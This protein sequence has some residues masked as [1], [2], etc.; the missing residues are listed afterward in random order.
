MPSTDCRGTSPAPS[1]RQPRLTI[2]RAVRSIR[3]VSNRFAF[4]PA[5]LSR[6]L[7]PPRTQF[8]LPQ[9]IVPVFLRKHPFAL[10]GARFHLLV[11]GVVFDAGPD[12]VVRV[13]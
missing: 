8:A 6:A 12:D 4:P 2:R 5:S 3:W 1:T 10:G 13:H 7:V 9:P 11:P